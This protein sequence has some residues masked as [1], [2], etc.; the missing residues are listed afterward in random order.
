MTGY[1]QRNSS[2]VPESESFGRGFSECLDP[3]ETSLR[4][5]VPERERESVSGGNP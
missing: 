4:G 1:R 2:V 5:W 3:K